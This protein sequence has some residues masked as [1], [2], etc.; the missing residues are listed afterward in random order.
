MQTGSDFYS[1]YWILQTLAKQCYV[2]LGFPLF[3][4]CLSIPQIDSL[5]T[6]EHDIVPDKFQPLLAA[7]TALLVDC[8]S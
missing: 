2:D 8:S 1:R 7:E 6:Y 5:G 3:L 4:G